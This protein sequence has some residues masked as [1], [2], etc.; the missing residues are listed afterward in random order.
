MKVMI[1]SDGPHA[2]LF[3]RTAWANAFNAC[4][5]QAELWDCKNVTAFDAFDTT[6]CTAHKKK[7]WFSKN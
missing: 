5:I 6:F 4:G 7:K 1:S 2:H 3:Q